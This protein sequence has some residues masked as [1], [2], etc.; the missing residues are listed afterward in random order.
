M[1]K[2]LVV[3][4]AGYIG[5]TV[6]TWLLDQGHQVHV[7]DDL[8]VGH[9]ELIQTPHFTKARAGDRIIVRELLT[10]ERFDCV[11]HF[12]AFAL[13]GESVSEPQKYQEN[14]VEQTRALLEVMLETKTFN[15]VFSSTCAIFGDPGNQ[16][17]DE[18]LA[19]KPINPYGQTKLDAELLMRKMAD[20]GLNTVAFR[21]FNAAGAEPKLRTGEWHDIETHLIPNVLMA[22]QSG[23]PV[24]VF[25]NDYPTSDGTC[26]RDYIHVLDLAIAH[27]MGTKRL[28]EGRSKG[29]EC[30]NLGS[31]TGMSVLEIIRA[32]E[33]VVG[34]K[35]TIEFKDRRPGDP[36]RLVAQSKKAKEVLGFSTRP[37]SLEFILRTAWDWQKILIDKRKSK[38]RRQ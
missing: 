14:N 6:S 35:I 4:G 20:Q 11:M 1:A 33:R 2:I 3:G 7:L 26:V 9:R 17:I 23:T 8:S 30:F 24:S 36:P 19:K 12:A 28:V 32:A 15:F 29:F 13:V 38:K 18:E 31:Q 37:D 22:A 21:Y 10:R 16:D 27:E 34:K 25:G 5:S